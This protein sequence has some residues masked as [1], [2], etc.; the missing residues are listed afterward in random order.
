[1]DEPKRERHGA[2][3]APQEGSA[4]RKSSRSYNEANCVEVACA[5]EHVFVRDSKAVAAGGPC[6]TFNTAAWQ[7]FINS[8][9]NGELG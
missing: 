8:I 1:M 7:P 2:V 3:S 4:W 6:L 5:D 9:K